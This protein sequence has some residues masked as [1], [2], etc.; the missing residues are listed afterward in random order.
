M[1]ALLTLG[2]ILT[3]LD[4]RLLNSAL[5]D[6]LFDV[7]LADFSAGRRRAVQH[8]LGEIATDQALL[9]Q[10]TPEAMEVFNAV[11]RPRDGVR[12]GSVV[13]LAQRPGLRSTLA[14]GLDPS[15]H[16]TQ[17]IYQTLYRLTANTRHT[18]PA[19]FTPSQT[20]A[21]RRAYGRLPSEQANDGIVPT[22]SQV[23]GEIIHAA[24]ADHLDV[25]G[26]FS[27]PTR[28]PAHY[29]WLTTGSGFTH[30]KFEAL[31]SDVLTFV[32]GKTA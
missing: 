9:P 26:H 10:L 29:D 6:E 28:T 8:L 27:D 15:A 22:R 18:R 16:V 17:A 30:E 25:L 24:R 32:F 19:G 13:A 4:D 1:A 14:A 20:A 11:T 23:W 21:L 2:S 31:W 12:C 7:L 5:L 3:R